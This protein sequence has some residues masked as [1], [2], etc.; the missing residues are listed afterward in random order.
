M[1]VKNSFAVKCFACL[2]IIFLVGSL[3]SCASTN[4]ASE[5]EYYE[6]PYTGI[7]YTAFRERLNLRTFDEGIEKMVHMTNDYSFTLSEDIYDD[8][9]DLASDIEE[10]WNDLVS[11][12]RSNPNLR[13]ELEYRRPFMDQI[14]EL[15]LI[16]HKREAAF[17][18]S[19]SEALIN[20]S[21]LSS[22]A[23]YTRQGR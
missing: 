14:K 18:M 10:D 4:R 5:P 3:F 8:I 9:L 19:I 11:C 7:Q 16:K 1:F 20:V 22:P 17:W 12:Y 23:G 2:I 15:A 21:T 6:S 13:T